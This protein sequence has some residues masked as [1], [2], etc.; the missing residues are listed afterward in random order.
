MCNKLS[1][2]GYLGSYMASCFQNPIVFSKRLYTFSLLP[3]YFSWCSLYVYSIWSLDFIFTNHP[4][5]CYHPWNFINYRRTTHHS[6]SY[7]INRSLWWISFNYLLYNFL[8][9]WKIHKY[10]FGFTGYQQNAKIKFNIYFFYI[11]QLVSR[12]LEITQ[13]L[14]LF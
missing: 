5:H 14:F 9:F 10:S 8:F 12:I 11:D 1:D 4:N 6:W 13:V 3:V 2:I 7:P